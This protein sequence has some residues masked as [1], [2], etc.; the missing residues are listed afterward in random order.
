MSDE[1]AGLIC[2]H[3]GHSPILL[4]GGGKQAFCGNEEC[5][6]F[7]WNPT[8]SR[9]HLEANAKEIRLGD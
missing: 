3:C 9:A 7:T 6:V 1:P 2:P 4:L 5:D 8:Q